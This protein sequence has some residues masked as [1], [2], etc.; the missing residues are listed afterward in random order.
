MGESNFNEVMSRTLADVLPETEQDFVSIGQQINPRIDRQLGY[1]G[2]ARFVLFYYEPRG[3]EVIWKDG[4]SY[5]FGTGAWDTFFR[6]IAPLA[7]SHG[8]RV[9]DNASAGKDVLLVD[10]VRR[11]AYFAQRDRA[12]RLVAEQRASRKA[13]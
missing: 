5:G 11:S 10:R 6:E 7:E 3:E 1:F 8:V 9:G 2:D 12:E 4:R 13:C